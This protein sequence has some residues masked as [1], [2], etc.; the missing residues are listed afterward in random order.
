MN[1]TLSYIYK[2][3][4]ITA[5]EVI[6]LDIREMKYI[7]E[8]SESENMTQAAEN[9]YISQPALSKALRKIES[10]IGFDI[11][12]KAGT[13]NVLTEQG[14]YLIN[15]IEIVLEA[16]KNFEKTIDTIKMNKFYVNFG[17]IPYYCTPFTT[18]FLYHFK[19]KF[20]DININ[21]IE[22]THDTLIEK[23]SKGEIDVIMT[24]KPAASKYIETFSGFQDDVSVAV[25]KNSEFY[26]KNSVTFNDLKEQTFNIVTSGNVLYQQIIDGCNE[27]G[28]KPRIGYQGSQ[29]GLLLEMTIFGNGICIMNRPM[30]Y[31]NINA[32]SLLKDMRII[33]LEPSPQ[34]YCFVSYKKNASISKE[35]IIFLKSLTEGLTDDTKKRIL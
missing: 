22:A 25:G 29:I 13:K 23:L 7:K 16:Y 8:L 10:N 31:D 11:F 24:E 26:Y 21:V 12:K 32:N 1:I 33:P 28:Y 35:I 9:L 18:M 14:K 4:I 6:S 34:C 5:K 20:P 27:A 17:V 30:I 19:E 3:T 15:N 2:N